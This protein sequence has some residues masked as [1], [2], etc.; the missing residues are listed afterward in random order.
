MEFMGLM[1]FLGLLCLWKWAWVVAYQLI[2]PA[3]R[4]LLLRPAN[5]SDAEL[6]SRA[7]YCLTAGVQSLLDGFFGW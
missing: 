7:Q 1:E 2:T 4:S 3:T 5:G 6:A